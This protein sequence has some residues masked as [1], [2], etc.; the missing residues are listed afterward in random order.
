MEEELLTAGLK[1]CIRD[2]PMDAHNG[3]VQAVDILLFQREPAAV[4]HID[5][6]PVQD[7]SLIHI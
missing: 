7:L 5:L 6:A 3:I 4:E 2:R 1:M